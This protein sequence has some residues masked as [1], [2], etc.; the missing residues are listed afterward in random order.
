MDNNISADV[1]D[2]RMTADDNSGFFTGTNSGEKDIPENRRYRLSV[3]GTDVSVS[4]S[5]EESLGSRL[6][7][8]FDMMT[9]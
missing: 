8:A 9:S 1:Y 7:K 6:A 2:G 5:G 3:N 4:F